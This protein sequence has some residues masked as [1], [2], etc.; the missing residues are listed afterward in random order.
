[1]TEKKSGLCKKEGGKKMF[2]PQRLRLACSQA[3]PLVQVVAYHLFIAGY[4]ILLKYFVA[5]WTIDEGKLAMTRSKKSRDS[6]K[7]VQKADSIL[8]Q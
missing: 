7:V 6:N 2:A 3:Y 8:I 4:I 5:R 1:M